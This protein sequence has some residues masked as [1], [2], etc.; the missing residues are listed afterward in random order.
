ME[1]LLVIAMLLEIITKTPKNTA[2]IFFFFFVACKKRVV[3]ENFENKLKSM[4][5]MNINRINFFQKK[6]I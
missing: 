3:V 1:F 4:E 5:Y 6:C 2:Q